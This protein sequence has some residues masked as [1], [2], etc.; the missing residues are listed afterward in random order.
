MEKDST[1]MS[2]R[3]DCLLS[4]VLERGSMEPDVEDGNLLF[5]HVESACS[6]CQ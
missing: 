5:W 4:D 2:K 3:L 1:D 6:V